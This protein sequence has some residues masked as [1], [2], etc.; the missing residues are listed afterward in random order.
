MGDSDGDGPDFHTTQFIKTIAPS[1]REKLANTLK[2]LL[3]PFV[4]D[5]V[6]KAKSL[7]R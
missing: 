1:E 3:P 2:Y 4:L 5:G 7:L 6:R